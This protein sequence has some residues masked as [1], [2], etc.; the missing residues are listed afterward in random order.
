MSAQR[1][2]K[3]LK[4]ALER[5][6]ALK[7]RG[8]VW[9]KF[10]ASPT[11]PNPLDPEFDPLFFVRAERGVDRF[12]VRLQPD[13]IIQ[14]LEESGRREIHADKFRKMWGCEYWCLDLKERQVTVWNRNGREV[15]PCTGNLSSWA[16]S[17]LT[18]DLNK[19]AR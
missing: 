6:H 18:V 16:I 2:R 14:V 8:D 3:R 10:E 17:G 13:L 19:V 12:G 11:D 5:N 7:E 15:L 4:K 9:V 1:T